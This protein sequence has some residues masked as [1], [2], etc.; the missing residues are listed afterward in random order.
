MITG[1]GSG[2][3]RAS[4]RRFAAEGATVVVADF[5]PG[6]AARVVEECGG[7]GLAIDTDV[8][9]EASGIDG[10]GETLDRYGRIDVLLTAAG[11]SAG[12]PVTKTSPA[13]WDDIFA[14]N[15]KGTFLWMQAALVPMLEAGRGSIIAV[16]SQL[17]F[18]GARGNAAYVASKGAVVSL[19]RTAAADYAR[20]GVRINT[21][22]PG[23]IETPLLERGFAGLAEPETARQRSI[24]RHPMA[25][26]GQPDE[27]AAAALFLASD[28][29]SFTTGSELRVDGGWLAG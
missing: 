13:T 12:G 4:A 25:R 26:F 29:S 16:A 8:T 6:A 15:V 1:G 14:V 24:D 17:A 28:E 7:G 5:D 3:G 9:E 10:I 21:L 20:R 2:I 23:A 11:R 19:V 27:V 22:V 18:A